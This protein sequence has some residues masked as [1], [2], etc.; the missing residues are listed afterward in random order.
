MIQVET[1]E[2]IPGHMRP[3]TRAGP[4]RQNFTKHRMQPGSDLSPSARELQVPVNDQ[5]QLSGVILHRHC[6]Q[7][8]M[9]DGGN[10][11]RVGIVTVRLR[12]ATRTKQPDPGRQ[13]RGHI[14][15]VDPGSGELLS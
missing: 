7:F 6:P 1:V 15:N 9:P 5:T 12:R 3:K 4:T 2:E 8:R 11:D 14:N 13:C 10:R